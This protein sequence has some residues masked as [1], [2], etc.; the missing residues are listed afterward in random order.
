MSDIKAVEDTLLR[1]CMG[2]REGV[3]EL[4]WCKPWID[5]H[6]RIRFWHIKTRIIC[7]AR[8]RRPVV[9]KNRK[10]AVVWKP[11]VRTE[12]NNRICRE[13]IEISCITQTSGK[14]S[15]KTKFIHGT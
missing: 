13:G 4:T 10:P 1:R 3:Y 6:W 8:N 15:S 14:S 5:R 2:V 11:F 12:T 9:G 7:G